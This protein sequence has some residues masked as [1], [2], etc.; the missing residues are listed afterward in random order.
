[1]LS[2]SELNALTLTLYTPTLRLRMDILYHL[3]SHFPFVWKYDC[4]KSS[5]TVLHFII[6]V[7][8][9]YLKKL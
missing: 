9:L 2:V 8:A 1:M 4:N 5:Q 6:T 3:I 7:T